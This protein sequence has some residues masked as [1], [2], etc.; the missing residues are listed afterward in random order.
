MAA[1]PSRL[2]SGVATMRP[3]TR[4]IP[5]RGNRS[6]PSPC[7]SLIANVPSVIP[8][9]HFQ[10]H[11]KPPKLAEKGEVW[12]LRIFNL[13][14]TG[15]TPFGRPPFNCTLEPNTDTKYFISVA[16][17]KVKSRTGCDKITHTCPR[18]E[19]RVRVSRWPVRCNEIVYNNNNVYRSV[20]ERG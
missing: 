4:R 19:R 3:Q 6:V 17:R 10:T 14:N 16:R 11:E 1:A 8:M 18:G 13:S 9:R 2:Y 12:D 5:R 20:R 7:V 15:N